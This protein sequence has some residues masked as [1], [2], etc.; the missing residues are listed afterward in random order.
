MLIQR[1][2]KVA[3]KLKKGAFVNKVEQTFIGTSEDIDRAIDDYIERCARNGWEYV[4]SDY[5]DEV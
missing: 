3:F 5:L 4:S 2:V 1:V